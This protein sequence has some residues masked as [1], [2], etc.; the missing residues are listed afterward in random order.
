MKKIKILALI[1]GIA[2]VA[3]VAFDFSPPAKG[4]I[5]KA[6]GVLGQ[7]AD[8]RG[9]SANAFPET[10]LEINGTRYEG[11]I[12]EETS[13]YDFM[14]KL[15]GEGKISF[16]EKNYLGMGKFIDTIDGMKGDGE[17]TW[18]YYVNG[19]KASVGVSNY[20][21]KPGDVVSWKYEKLLTY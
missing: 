13:V 20:Q 3:Y 5:P 14:A 10:V 12:A 15:R 17:K 11:E 7:P 6:E 4:E 8:M 2:L 16:T 9:E 18:I 21:I 1:F 19:K